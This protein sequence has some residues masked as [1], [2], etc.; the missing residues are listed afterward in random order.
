MPRVIA[1]VDRAAWRRL[2]AILPE[3]ELRF[4]DTSAQ[5]ARELDAGPCD[6]LIVGAHFDESTAIGAIERVLARDEMFSVVCIRGR[7]F[8]SA[9]GGPSLE[10]LRVASRALGAQN[11]IDL[12]EY[13]DDEA[14]N[15]RI[16][17]ML[18]RLLAVR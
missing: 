3:C 14:G 9:L 5:L 16:R 4:V 17:A 10:A 12:L 11:F 15:A 2:R 18:E 8:A 6:M 13:P 1:A 7:P